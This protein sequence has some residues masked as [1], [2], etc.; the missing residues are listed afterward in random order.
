MVCADNFTRN[1]IE[2]H[3]QSC[4]SHGDDSSP[5]FIQLIPHRRSPASRLTR[6]AI[7]SRIDDSVQNP[8]VVS[9]FHRWSARFVVALGLLAT[10]AAPGMS[11]ERPAKRLASIVGVAVEEYA[12]AI[13]PQGKLVSD[14]EYEEAVSFL[15]DAREVAQRLSGDKALQAQA[16]LDS[17][18]ALV[19]A[20]RPPADLD[21]L[22]GRF[23]T[24]LGA[25]AA[26]DLPTRPIDL[27]AG[28]AIYT[29]HCASCHGA[30][31][32]GDG[33][34]AKGMNPPPPALG[35]AAI[36]HDVSPALMFR[37]SSV[38]I[39]GT[40]MKGW[41][42]ELTPDDRWNVISYIN[43]LRAP[44]ANAPGE[45]IY[46][47][48]C[49]GCHGASGAGDGPLVA[50]LSKIPVDLNSFAWQAERSDAQIIE[51]VRAGVAGTAMP[52]TRDLD[53]SEYAKLVAHVRQL[54]LRN[55][56][57]QLAGT[58]DSLDGAAVARKVMAI[59]DE[60]LTAARGGR[61]SEAGD[62]AFDAYI[63]FEPLETPARAR[64]PGLVATME[65]HFAD[66]KGAVKASDARSA[67]RSRDAIAAGM[68]HIIEMT[69]P[70]AGFWGAFFQSFLIILREGFEAILVIGAIV[71]FLIKTGN[72]KRLRDIWVGVGAALAASAVTAVILATALK[73]LPATREIIEG[74][75]MLIAVAV[76]FSVSYWLISKVEA[77]KWQAF[78]RDKVN[79]ALSH[80]GGTALT[81]V[82]FLAVYREGA[83]TA[84]FLQALFA[85]GAALPLTLGIAVG[86]VAL[87][88]IFT[89]FHRYGVKIPLRPF[90][91][92]TSA[93]L[94]YM[95]FVFMGKGIREL[96]EGNVIPI[97]ILPGWPS[98]EA[99]GIF[100]SVQ[101]LLAQLALVALF[102]FALAKTFWPKRSVTLPTVPPSRRPVSEP[103]E[104]RVS[105]LE[106]KVESI[107][108]SV[109]SESIN[110]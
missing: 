22:H 86:F 85:E 76:L 67:E 93:L 45:G 10:V 87:A 91:G 63:A 7:P 28:R 13:D 46:A 21:A 74:A 99:M 33:D 54:S 59:L 19:K 101:T 32:K 64:N 81:V 40:P 77:A 92:V 4:E 69:K 5:L 70:A 52:P 97:T 90:F 66:F 34:R 39:A 108:Q 31:G 16:L 44:H 106:R 56:A 6:Q 26:L 95:A 50:A 48:R 62:L 94:Y 24:S 36:M 57:V 41:A 89:L 9:G 98:V 105:A 110:R 49:A 20:K 103:I 75:T 73:A 2:N 25:D 61:R 83:E 1:T 42:N 88:I 17:L 107:E 53:E 65:R 55:P 11:Q 12:K 82:A 60:A 104:D 78:I 71:A 102:V 79:N 35:D 100:P 38:G 51:A 3:S 58:S 96:Q 109:G 47:Q 29:Q 14:M 68:P 37:I 15:A 8:S 80:G 43:T 18:S 27:D 84:L 72:R 23:M 30:T